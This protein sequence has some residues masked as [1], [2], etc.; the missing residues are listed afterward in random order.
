[1]RGRRARRTLQRPG[2]AK[3]NPTGLAG[4]CAAA[5]PRPAGPEESR[6]AL[7]SRTTGSAAPWF[8][9][10]VQ[11]GDYRCHSRQPLEFWRRNTV[12]IQLV[13]T[14]ATG[15]IQL[16]SEGAAK[17]FG[18]PPAENVCRRATSFKLPSTPRRRSRQRPLRPRGVGS[19]S[20]FSNRAPIKVANSTDVSLSDATSATGAFVIAQTDIAYAPADSVPPMSPCR[21]RSINELRMLAFASPAYKSKT[22]S[23]PGRRA[24]RCMTRVAGKP[25]A[26]AIDDRVDGDNRRVTECEADRASMTRQHR[27]LPV[28][29]NAT[30]SRRVKSSTC[31]ASLWARE[32]RATRYAEHRRDQRR[33]ST[34]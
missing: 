6:P 23:H 12:F 26:G 9:V 5:A 10:V 15:L 22:G 29:R 13:S 30:Q 34:H 31:Q 16:V 24:T 3:T 18:R 32:A 28:G 4:R 17:Q 2:R 19:I 11:A 33:Y 1:M 7:L 25:R 20:L 21:R 8:G 14:V 27:L